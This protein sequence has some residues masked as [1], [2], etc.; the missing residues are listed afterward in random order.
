MINKT[1]ANIMLTSLFNQKH[2]KAKEQAN[3]NLES[4]F[5][6]EKFKTSFYKIRSLQ[7]DLSKLEDNSNEAK[8]IL[9]QIEEERKIL[10]A[11]LKNC[12][13]TKDDLKP[14]YE[15]KKCNDTGFVQGN[16]CT[17]YK[18]EQTKV[19]LS[20]SG[21]NKN[22]LP[23]FDKIDFSIF[24]NDKDPK[25]KEKIEKL[26]S[27]AKSFISSN[28]KKLTLYIFGTPGTGK[29]Y[30]S[31]CILNEAIENNMF[32]IYTTAFEINQT[33][34]NYHLAKLEQK[35]T[36]ISPFLNCELLIIDDLGSENILK[37]VTNE[38][39]Y[40]IIDTRLRKGLKTIFTSN[41]SPETI[42]DRYDQ[43]IFSRIFNKQFFDTGYMGN[44]DLRF[45]K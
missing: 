17:C 24:K 35:N 12:G 31:E 3:K 23:S 19:F 43:R 7:F 37:N 45:K 10:N 14:Q 34:L 9:K 13:F 21:I 15:C 32:S 6:N 39:L 25:L 5:K 29:T 30:L 11:E 36:I 38:Y 2:K 26:Y 27:Y 20:E 44:T 16:P 8:Q 40:L 42:R 28:N 41:Y 33:L 1:D 18:V 4:C 22:S